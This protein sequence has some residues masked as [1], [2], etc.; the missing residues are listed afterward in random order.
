VSRSIPGKSY[1][2]VPYPS[3]RFNPYPTSR[4]LPYLILSFLFLSL[5]SP[6][7]PP[8]I[9]TSLLYIYLYLFNSTLIFYPHSSPFFNFFEKLLEIKILI[10]VNCRYS[11][12]FYRTTPRRTFSQRPNKGNLSMNHSKFILNLRQLHLRN[13]IPESLMS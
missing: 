3:S 9:S 12:S 2:L 8:L 4:H 7:L 5:L 6:Y 10:V 11:S 13:T 1:G